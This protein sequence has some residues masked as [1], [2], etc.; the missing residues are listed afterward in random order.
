VKPDDITAFLDGMEIL[1]VKNV[2]NSVYVA[3][4]RATGETELNRR[5]FFRNADWWIVDRVVGNGGSEG[6]GNDALQRAGAGNTTEL[7]VLDRK[8]EASLKR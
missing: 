7:N 6:A 1:P 5:C 4:Q 3:A 8:R 2:G